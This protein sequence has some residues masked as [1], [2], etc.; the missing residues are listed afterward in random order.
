[1]VTTDKRFPSPDTYDTHIY[2]LQRPASNYSS[3]LRAF[4]VVTGVQKTQSLSGNS[5]T[6]MFIGDDWYGSGELTP[7][8]QI[9]VYSGAS[10]PTTYLFDGTTFSTISGAYYPYF[11]NLFDGSGSSNMPFFLR[12]VQ[13]GQFVYFTKVTFQSQ[14]NFTTFPS[15]N[16]PWYFSNGAFR[17]CVVDINQQAFLQ[18]LT[19]NT[20][21]A[22]HGGSVI[23]LARGWNGPASASVI[24]QSPWAG[25]DSRIAKNIAEIYST[26]TNASMVSTY[27]EVPS[28]DQVV[29]RMG[30]NGKAFGETSTGIGC[31]IRGDRYLT[32]HLLDLK[33]S[34]D[35]NRFANLPAISVNSLHLLLAD[36]TYRIVTLNTTS[37]SVRL[38][39]YLPA[40]DYG[41][42]LQMPY[43]ANKAIKIA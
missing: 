14:S 7:T 32:D 16:G 29:L 1:M 6:G 43:Q 38:D 40:D 39:D 17:Q 42:Y 27:M 33:D 18:R 2:I 31:L 28:R 34:T 19:S 13:Y 21:V 37:G 36:D 3:T 41:L 12:Q 23:D 10:V 25:D 30:V 22:T 20:L 9:E 35:K 4:D 11:A 26:T 15:Y 24:D 8:K 5:W